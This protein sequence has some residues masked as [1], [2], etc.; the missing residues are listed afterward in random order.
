MTYA[1]ETRDVAVHGDVEDGFGAVA[2]E[3]RRNFRDRQDLGAGCAAYLG[4][5]KVVDLWAGVAD[6][7]TGKPFEHDT[8]TVI[9]SCTK[10]IMA[11]CAYLLV[12]EGRLDLDAP[13]ARY[14]P[15]FAQAGKSAITLRQALA[16]R[17]GLSYLD[18]DLTTAEVIAWDPVIDAIEHQ[19]PH[20]APT[21]GHAYH[22]ITIG[23]L[24]GEVIKRITGLTPGT[25][26]RQ[27][28]GDP[29]GLDTWIGLPASARDQVA[30][31]EAPLP[32]DDS[33][34]AKAFASFQ[35]DPSVER[36]ATLGG[37]FA[38]P[39]DSDGY[40]SFN[41]PAVQAAEIPGAGGISS[42]ESLAKLYAA[43]VTGLGSGPA[44]LTR[45]SIADG[46]RVQSAGTQL[47]GQPDDGASWGTGFQISS[48]PGQPLL[49]PGSFGH[50][51]AGGQLAFADV[52]FGAS[53]GY[54]TNQMGGYGDARARLLVEALRSAID[55]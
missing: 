47:T 8:A 54:V 9:F 14:W 26:F 31:M 30:F 1:N 29:L 39:A 5:R 48:A 52:D 46:L 21:D 11:I 23:W 44:L 4:G 16:H 25:Y 43:C 32:D 27:T 55:G 15:E 13:M 53:F 24:V 2:D 42:A 50:T 19:A 33:D 34:F 40:V 20:S 7:R 12:Q 6:R 35:F 41:A 51:R 37:A 10:G 18:R 3:F 45:A 38:F 17:A 36:T 22:A 49:G 28:L